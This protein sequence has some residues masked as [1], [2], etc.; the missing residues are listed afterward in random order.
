MDIQLNQIIF[1]MINFGVVLGVLTYF[2]YKPVLKLL[3]DRRE[4]V[5]SA[6]TAAAEMMQEKE[7]LERQ[8]ESILLKASQEAK[9]IEDGMRKESR[10]Q[11]K[12]A[13]EQS[14]QEIVVREAKFS[15]EL[16]KMKKQEIA[17]MQ[18]EIKKAALLMAE[19]VLNESIDAKKHQKLLDEQITKIIEKL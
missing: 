10:E 8:R 18:D 16:A 1:Q 15:S 6:A 4:R 12:L 19:K 11:A 9:K 17:S 14:K 13:L 2:I 3:N 5:A 7:E